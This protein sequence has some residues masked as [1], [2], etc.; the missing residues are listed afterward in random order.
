MTLSICLPDTA[1]ISEQ[2]VPS[3][4]RGCFT[5]PHD[6]NQEKTFTKLL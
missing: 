4:P 6:I 2:A 3:A 5:F 1:V